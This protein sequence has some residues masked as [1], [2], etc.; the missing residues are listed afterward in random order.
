MF[1]LHGQTVHEACLT[2]LFHPEDDTTQFLQNINWSNQH[3]VTYQN[4][5]TFTIK[6]CWYYYSYCYALCFSVNYIFFYY[7]LQH[8]KMNILWLV[9]QNCT[10]N[11]KTS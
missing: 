10:Q 4:T 6:L 1:I 9:T 8:I 5:W 2:W 3:G 11:I 7:A